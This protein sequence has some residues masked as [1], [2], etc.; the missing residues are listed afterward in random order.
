MQHDLSE[1]DP[2]AM[3]ARHRPAAVC[4]WRLVIACSF[5]WKASPKQVPSFESKPHTDSSSEWIEM[6]LAR[7]FK[8]MSFFH[9]DFLTMERNNGPGAPVFSIRRRI[10][11]GSEAAQPWLCHCAFRGS[12]M[13]VS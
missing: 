2:P 13:H 9:G 4:P 10:Q 7:D 6:H 11:V 3:G 5:E 12:N 1:G 8:D